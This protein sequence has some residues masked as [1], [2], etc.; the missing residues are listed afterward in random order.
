[1]SHRPLAILLI[2][3]LGFQGLF[4]AVVICLGSDHEYEPTKVVAA[5][6]L[7]CDHVEGWLG[8]IPT[9][10]HGAEC[11]CI[12]IE[13]GTIELLGLPRS[14]SGSTQ[15]AL[16]LPAPAWIVMELGHGPQLPLP[17]F[18][19]SGKQ[20]TAIISSTRLIL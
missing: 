17:R 19:P 14:D 11:G 13:I 18:D 4:N 6:D 16:I 12:D 10:D 2:M 7:A 1:M 3:L 15:V 5:H 8:L 20:R 9:D